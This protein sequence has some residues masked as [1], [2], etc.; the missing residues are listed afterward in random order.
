MKK[1][2]L[3]ALI[4]FAACKKPADPA[5]PIRTVDILVKDAANSQPVAGAI[6]SLRRCADL[7]CYFGEVIEFQDT[8]DGNGIL[9][10]PP[11]KYSK[12]PAW[13]DAIYV[14]KVNYW[15]QFFSKSASV[16]ITPYGWVSL[17]IIRGTDY[18]Q[19]SLLKMNIFSANQPLLSAHEFSTAADSSVVISGFG[20][21]LNK[22][23]W[24]VSDNLTVYNS[25]TFNQ[26]F[27]RLDTAKNITLNY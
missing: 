8:T 9:H 19:G 12:V 11:D 15:P 23:D 24:Q 18:P 26:Q 21:E 2:C 3:I 22:V 25:G 10:V 27:P 20:N 5:D 7:G 1:I 13:N 17:R 14:T 16:S 4:L 6:V